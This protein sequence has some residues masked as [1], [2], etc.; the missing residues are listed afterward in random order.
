MSEWSML[1]LF[2]NFDPEPK[3]ASDFSPQP[4]SRANNAVSQKY[5]YEKTPQA[6]LS[7]NSTTHGGGAKPPVATSRLHA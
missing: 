4:Y 5:K 7:A 1:P 2:L 3:C 6:Q